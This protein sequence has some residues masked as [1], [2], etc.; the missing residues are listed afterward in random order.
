MRP[1]WTSG[2]GANGEKRTGRKLH[3]HAQFIPDVVEVRG[4]PAAAGWVAPRPAVIVNHRPD[5]ERLHKR[6]DPGAEC[7]RYQAEIRWKWPV[8]RGPRGAVA[9]RLEAPPI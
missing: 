8:E 6:I 5:R 9:L 7:S 2:S 3:D 1:N 4:E